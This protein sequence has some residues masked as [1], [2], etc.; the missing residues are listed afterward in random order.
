MH[1]IGSKSHLKAA[2]RAAEVL[3]VYEEN[4]DKISVGVY[5]AGSDER[6]DYAISRVREVEAFLQQER[7][8]PCTFEESVTQL[9]A[10]FPDER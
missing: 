8:G 1:E 6:V 7:H 4:Y 2:R 3:A 10:L 9:E 5:E